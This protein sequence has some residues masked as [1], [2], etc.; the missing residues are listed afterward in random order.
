[1]TDR[2]TFLKQAG[3]LAAALPLGSGL[4]APAVAVTKEPVSAD[5]WIGLKQLFNQDP[6]YIHF[7]NFLVT[8][9]PKPVRDAIEQHRAHIDRNPGLAMDWDL[10]E[11]ELREHDVR[12]W[13]GKY[14][15]AKP[16]QIA[17]TGSTTEGL[18]I[19]YGGLHIRPD[20]EILTTEHEHSCARSILNFRQ[21]RDGTQVRRIR[22][23][24][25][26]AQVSADEIIGSI[27]R[28]IQPNTRVLGMTW[29][30]S[31]SG[32]KLPLG[33]IGELVEEHNRNRDAKDRIIYVVD[34][35]HGFGVENL[36]FPDMKC[37]YFVA[38]T[39]KWMFGPRGTGIV[40]AR[41]EQMTDLTPTIPTFSEATNFATTMTPGGYHSFEHR[42]ALNKAFE[43]HLQL[44][45]A[46]V[47]ARIHQL[48]SYM[49]ERLQAQRTIELVTP[50]DPALS[51]GF[52]FFRVK[53]QSS[54]DVAAWL[55]KNRMVV[56]AVSRDVGPVVRTAPGLL[57]SEA[58]VDRFMALLSQR[59]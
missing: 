53:D 17:L 5:K 6:D 25:D 12:V 14:L 51:A 52:S 47:Q 44:G 50:M 20:Q 30:Q 45:K 23:F 26:P 36:D 33:A 42:W 8:S 28:S 38:G 15:N 37:D 55:M 18:A 13:A 11:T 21:Q 3:L 56:D 35:V 40:C 22:L 34:G 4:I 7:S 10:Q 31:G 1:M 54:D 58:E 59:T 27:A 43:L 57:N 48:N 29:V 39:H 2:R 46:D 16:G 41:S 24:K 32:V 19:I 49:K 9:H